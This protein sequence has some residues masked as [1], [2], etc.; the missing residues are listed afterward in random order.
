MSLHGCTSCPK[1]LRC[2]ICGCDCFND[3]VFVASDTPKCTAFT[4]H[5]P[6]DNARDAWVCTLGCGTVIPAGE[7]GSGIYQRPPGS[8]AATAA[9]A[10]QRAAVGINIG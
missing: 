2:T 8:R 10:D 1:C 6:Y 9:A 5:M 4:H 7:A 3:Q